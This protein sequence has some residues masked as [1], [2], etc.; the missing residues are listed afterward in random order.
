M[1]WHVKEMDYSLL[2]Y[3][4]WRLQIRAKLLDV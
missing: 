1:V 2:L 4:Y 3:L